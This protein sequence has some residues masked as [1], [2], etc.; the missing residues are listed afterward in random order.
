MFGHQI[1]LNFNEFG[2]NHY[3]LAGGLI[4]IL[5]KIAALV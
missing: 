1:N 3:T 2:N 4:S 5:I